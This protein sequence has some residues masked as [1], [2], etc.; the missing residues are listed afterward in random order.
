MSGGN[1]GSMMNNGNTGSM[2]NN[3]NTGSMMNN[4]NTGSMMSGGN[5]G[6][7]M[8]GGNNNSSG[9]KQ[10]TNGSNNNNN[11]MNNNNKNNGNQSNNKQTT[12]NTYKAPTVYQNVDPNNKISVSNIEGFKGISLSGNQLDS[13][14][15]QELRKGIEINQMKGTFNQQTSNEISQLTKS[16]IGAVNQKMVNFNSN[17]QQEWYRVSSENLEYQKQDV[18]QK[19]G[20]INSI[21]D[22]VF[23]LIDTFVSAK[24]QQKIISVYDKITTNNFFVKSFSTSSVTTQKENSILENSTYMDFSDCL[25][26]LKNA[27]NVS[28]SQDIIIQ[29]VDFN[30]TLSS[31]NETNKTLNSETT[32]NFYH[33][34][35]GEKLDITNVCDEQP[36]SLKVPT[37]VSNLN[38]T[39]IENFR[40]KRINIYDRKDDFY[41][42]KCITY[43]NETSGSE[44]PVN[45]RISRYFQGVSFECSDG[46]TFTGFDDNFFQICDC[47]AVNSTTTSKNI[48]LMS[49]LSKSNIDLFICIDQAFDKSTLKKN[50]GFYVLALV[51]VGGA[52]IIIFYWIVSSNN[53]LTESRFNIVFQNDATMIGY[54]DNML[55]TPIE[56]QDLEETEQQKILR[57]KY[58]L[59]M[60]RYDES[61]DN[62][63]NENA[64]FKNL[65]N[66]QNPVIEG[67]IKNLDFDSNKQPI[68]SGFPINDQNEKE[69]V[70]NLIEN[71]D[72]NE[73]IK[74]SKNSE[75]IAP[76]ANELIENK[77]E[78]KNDKSQKSIQIMS[79]EVNPDLTKN[80]NNQLSD[81]KQDS[82]KQSK[83]ESNKEN[84]QVIIVDNQDSTN[85]NNLIAF[86]EADKSGGTNKVFI[87][88]LLKN[89]KAKR[90]LMKYD[91]TIKDLNQMTV[92]QALKYDNRKFLVYYWDRVRF[93]HYIIHALFVDRNEIPV[94]MRLIS[95][96]FF[97]S[98]QFALNAVFY[99]DDYISEKNDLNS[100]L[101]DVEYV[102]VYQLSK[103]IWSAI[104][105]SIPILI[106]NP[107]LSVPQDVYRDYNEGLLD[108][109][110][111]SANIHCKNFY[112]SMLW[113]YTVY[114]ILVLIFHLLSWYY[115]TAFCGVYIK[116][117]INWFIGGIISL[118][119]QFIISQPLLPLIRTTIRALAKKYQNK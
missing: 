34:D 50:P 48:N 53:L 16:Y 19:Q 51:L 77:T 80:N 79:R 55:K 3:G 58:K 68:M 111:Q 9:N 4:G 76:S 105:S 67:N 44:I 87:K 32:Y 112:K 42:S 114:I 30:T 119:I 20:V 35:T 61:I 78:L 88:P 110:P 63:I 92:K 40:P 66:E 75:N 117:S 98:F 21:K 108:R 45:D 103:S 90:G 13:G 62:Q 59:E 109:D 52:S 83:H 29:V 27:Y 86:E 84:K 73:E 116:S 26:L 39:L 10:P 49:G 107:L 89:S 72:I 5:T 23:T 47:K 100:S 8:S 101:N 104:I 15:A 95:L 2:M 36:I 41:T 18:K 65:N 7:M 22:E 1:T 91:F 115:V 54:N 106:L 33:P 25:K 71:K 69:Q 82:K 6:S 74:E 14:F 70:I 56:L 12:T 24:T 96:L 60:Q 11:Q 64:D 81:Q 43:I 57:E 99:S 37:D 85:R 118:L 31:Y 46:C 94:T 28:D 38:V 102:I 93:S 97:I 17:D 113:R